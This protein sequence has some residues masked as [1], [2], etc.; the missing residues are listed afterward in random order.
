HAE[1]GDDVLQRLVALQRFL[2][3]AR[4]VVVLLPDDVHVENTRGGIE[5]IDRR[6]NALRGDVAR[7]NGGGVQVRERGGRR[8]VGQVVGGHVDGFHRGEGALGGRGYALLHGAHF[9]RQRRLI[10]DRRRNTTQERRHF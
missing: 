6:I 5:R 9:G 1:N 7:E 4:R 8:G 2:N 10:A 3:R